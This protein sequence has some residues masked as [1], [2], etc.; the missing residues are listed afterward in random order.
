MRIAQIAPLIERVPPKRYGGTERVIHAL[1]EELV[2]RGHEVTLFA[3]GDS[4]T[5]AKLVSV[6]PQ[7]LREANIKDLYGANVWQMLN[8]GMA[9][10][11]QD[12][13]DVI[14]DHTGFYS[15]PAANLS[16]APVV[17]TIHGALDLSN[18][19]IYS[20]LGKRVSLVT[21]SKSQAMPAPNLNYAGTVY[22]GLSMENYPFSG[23]DAGYLLVVGRF[24]AE[25]GIHLAVQAARNLNMP[26]VIAAKL[27]PLHM[28]YFAEHIKPF[29]SDRIRWVG[30]VGQDE[31]N[32]L[33]SKALCL[34]HPVTWRE[35]FGLTLIEAMA[36][37]APVVGFRRGSIPEVIADGKTGYV[38]EDVPE[39]V[40]AV[41]RVG[42]IKR[43]DC[44]RYSLE[45]FSAARMADGYE[46]IYERVV[47]K[48]RNREVKLESAKS[49]E[50]TGRA[51]LISN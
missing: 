10:M 14:H 7:A 38:V 30:E 15:L 12:E 43:E 3:S 18:R 36:C 49:A 1:T 17:V 34:L 5:S 37:G 25:K 23:K 31:R 27:E 19:H 48:K 4:I 50:Q 11:R 8:I 46:A 9:Y 6:Y 42:K 26:L 20:A 33:M 45:T 13:F 40:E 24:Q 29:L 44:R 32:D 16:R 22:N 41:K 35:P 39:M 47:K 21:V 28:N 2:K 51:D